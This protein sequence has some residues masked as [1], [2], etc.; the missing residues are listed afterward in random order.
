M[1]QQQEGYCHRCSA[2]DAVVHSDWVDTQLSDWMGV[3][4]HLQLYK[5]ESLKSVS[6]VTLAHSF[7]VG[8]WC[9]SRLVVGFLLYGCVF[10]AVTQHN[11][12]TVQTLSPLMLCLSSSALSL[13]LAPFFLSVLPLTLS[14]PSLGL[15]VRPATSRMVVLTLTHLQDHLQTQLPG[16]YRETL[17]FSLWPCLQDIQYCVFEKAYSKKIMFWCCYTSCSG[18]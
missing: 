12:H 1:R 10:T 15:S 2:F 14:N 9:S 6:L 8:E 18:F 4:V 5:L 16:H 7:P 11:S 3:T 17:L 13:L